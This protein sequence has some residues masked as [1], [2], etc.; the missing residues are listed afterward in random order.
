MTEHVLRVCL[1]KRVLVSFEATHFLLAQGV[2]PP[3]I[4]E[5]GVSLPIF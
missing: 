1:H 3:L 4:A 5:H 2:A